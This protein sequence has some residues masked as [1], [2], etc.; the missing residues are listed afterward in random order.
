MLRPEIERAAL[1]PW[2]RRRVIIDGFA[3]GAKA[4]ETIAGG[5]AIGWRKR[6]L[7]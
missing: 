6:R 5:F 1:L 4:F 7:N 2:S 3:D